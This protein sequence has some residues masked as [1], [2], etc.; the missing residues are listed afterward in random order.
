[1]TSANLRVYSLSS[2]LVAA[3]RIQLLSLPSHTRS[4][5]QIL[6]I[7]LIPAPDDLRR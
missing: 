1:M 7:W 6:N 4:H 3:V 2:L 5:A